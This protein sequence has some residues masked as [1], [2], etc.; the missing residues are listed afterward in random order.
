LAIT[1]LPLING[2]LRSLQISSLEWTLADFEAINNLSLSLLSN[3]LIQHISGIIEKILKSNDDSDY[4][5]K[6]VLFRYSNSHILLSSNGLVLNVLQL[7]QNMLARILLITS[8]NEVVIMGPDQVWTALVSSGMNVN[9]TLD[10]KTKNVLRGTYVMALQYYTELEKLMAQGKDV[11]TAKSVI[12]IM[13]ASLVSL[14]LYMCRINYFYREVNV[15][16]SFLE[17][18]GCR[19]RMSA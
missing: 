7:M 8:N 9:W 10:E 13:A 5:A 4:Y 17:I 1:V 19:W 14:F 12:E 16:V 2:T 15:S 18:G 6:K 3:E 11:P